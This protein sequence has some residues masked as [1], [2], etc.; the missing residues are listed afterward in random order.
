METPATDSATTAPTVRT[1]ERSLRGLEARRGPSSPPPAAPRPRKL[2]LRPAGSR[3]FPTRLLSA[4]EAGGL[5]PPAEDEEAEAES[6]VGGT[7]ETWGQAPG[8]LL[9]LFDLLN[10]KPSTYAQLGLEPSD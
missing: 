8:V 9:P 2:P 4:T 6:T 5:R 1:P 7:A 10:H 3:A